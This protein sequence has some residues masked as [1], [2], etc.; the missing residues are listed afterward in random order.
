MWKQTIDFEDVWRGRLFWSNFGVAILR[1]DL[2]VSQ[3]DF[4]K[5][6]DEMNILTIGTA[7]FI[8]VGPHRSS[9]RIEQISE[10]A[11]G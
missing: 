7:F 6:I 3:L 9:S 8:D 5:T 10:E 1:R 11:A 4:A 2:V